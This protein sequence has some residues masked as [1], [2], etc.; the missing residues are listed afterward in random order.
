MTEEN[1]EIIVVDDEEWVRRG[2]VIKLRK[3]GLPVGSVREFSEGEPVVRYID[4]GGRPDIMICDIKMSGLDGLSLAAML[5][6]RLPDLRIIISS[7]YGEFEYAKRAIQVGVSDYLLKPIDNMELYVALKSCMESISLFRRNGERLS[8]LQTIERENRA[9]SRLGRAGESGAGDWSDLFPAYRSG[10]ARFIC[11]Y[12]RLPRMGEA[13]FHDLVNRAG[14]RYLDRETIDNSVLYS[15]AAGEYVLLFLS[16][17]SSGGI[18]A[19]AA[20]LAPRIRSLGGSAGLSGTGENPDRTVMEALELM[21]YG[22]LLEHTGLICPGD[23]AGR[24]DGYRV[25]GHHLSALRHALEQGNE[26]ALV[27][28]LDT[29]EKEIAARLLSYRCLENAYLQI[30]LPASEILSAGEQKSMLFIKDAYKFAS[31]RELFDFIRESYRL[32]LKMNQRA[33]AKGKAAIIRD[34]AR[35]IDEHFN[36]Y[37][38]LDYFAAAYDINASYLSLLFKEVMGVHFQEYLSSV[39][40]RNAKDYLTSGR[41]S[42]A[43]VAEKTGY[44]N[45]FYFSRAFKKIEGLTPTEFMNTAGK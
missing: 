19:L 17:G 38:T 43:K 4:G 30:L 33:A 6:K 37:L 34:I 11:V 29:L 15:C 5:R 32:C 21:K 2:M 9:R 42:I 28:V 41:Y 25:A 14:P 27:P 20:A 35:S 36:E 7:G 40:I 18:K 22:V 45:R 3:S 39:R 10:A 13:D 12:F 23:I 16:A 26:K 24:D 44:T 8:Y 31:L 1:F